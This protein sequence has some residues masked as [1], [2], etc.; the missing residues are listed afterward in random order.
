MAGVRAPVRPHIQNAGFRP[1]WARRAYQSSARNASAVARG[2]SRAAAGGMA[3]RRP[4][5]GSNSIPFPANENSGLRSRFHKR[6]AWAVARHAELRR[7]QENRY[8]GL[9]ENR[10]QI[11]QAEQRGNSPGSGQPGNGEFA[12]QEIPVRMSRPLHFPGMRKIKRQ[13]DVTGDQFVG[14]GAIVDAMNRGEPVRC[15]PI[16]QLVADRLERGDIDDRNAKVLRGEVKVREGLLMRR[17]DLQSGR[18]FQGCA[19]PQRCAEADPSTEDLARVHQERWT[20]T[21]QIKDFAIGGA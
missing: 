15:I 13:P 2:I 4:R 8:P 20:T 17:I 6:V 1:G 11:L 10:R 19:G 12:D 5:D 9:R 7:Q 21:G 3:S 14:N 16:V 18:R